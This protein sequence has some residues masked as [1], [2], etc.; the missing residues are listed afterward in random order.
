MALPAPA[1]P[2]L[3][4]T[5]FSS[6][7][8][9]SLAVCSLLLAAPVL[10]A[11]ES[12]P[13]D[14]LRLIG[15]QSL[16]RRL[17]FRDTLV[18]GLSGLDYDASRHTWIS[19][20]DDKAEF[21]PARCY[22]L[23]L[24]YDA[25]RFNSVEVTDVVVLR[26]A[27]GSPYPSREQ[28]R[29]RGGEIP[30]LEA[31]RLDPADG[32][33]WYTSEGERAFGM[34]PFVRHAARDGRL[35]GE[36]PQ[37]AMFLAHPQEER[38][39]RQNLSFEGLTLAPDGQTAWLA[40]EGPLYQDGPVP[41]PAAG[42]VSRITHLDR[43]GKI[44]A[45]YAYPLDAIPVPPAPGR[46]A[47]N[48]VSELLAVDDHQFLVLE[49]S[50]SQAA[51]RVFHYH[52]R[53][54]AIDVHGATEVSTI[55]ALAATPYQPV[56][57]RLVLDFDRLGQPWVDCLEGMTWGPRLANGH[58]T[59]VFVS[60][61]N[62][63]AN[64]QTQFWAFEVVPPPPKKAADKWDQAFPGV[65]HDDQRVHGFV[66]EYRWL[67]N[68]HLCR[69]T[70]AG[71]TYTSSEAAYQS[72]KYPPAERDIFT[73]LD[74]DAAKKRSRAVSYDTASWEARK[75]QAMREILWAKFSQNPDLAEKL[76]ATGRRHL[77]ETNWWG[78]KIWGVSQGEGRNLLG[79]ML[80]E[81]RDRLVRE[82]AAPPAPAGSE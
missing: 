25:T 69:V 3:T 75:E 74:P 59:L 33:L 11:A 58:A 35:L 76:I 66:E 81:V 19:I 52:I 42:A 39:P 30:D 56:A 45:Q 1:G 50:G 71:R 15:V 40:M 46:I 72:A 9:I 73:T 49:R 68:F 62:F 29:V 79:Q 41:T 28:A 14:A 5:P 6:F 18:G 64:Q 37:P 24:D 22:T 23:A 8:R 63:S 70:W 57:K 34:N 47:D 44:L 38:G 31:V 48:G 80:M 51:D 21:G 53:L 7:P 13:V 60:D 43:A 61:D 77:E 26:Q 82:K 65:I 54:Y 17:P 32:T 27:D 36:V 55:A 20:S 12:S 4:A 10:P 67:S 16:P 78:D 2:I